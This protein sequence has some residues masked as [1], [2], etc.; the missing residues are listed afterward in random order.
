VLWVE[1]CDRD[2]AP[3]KGELDKWDDMVLIWQAQHNGEIKIVEEFW[4]VTTEPGKYYSFNPVNSN[5]AARIAFGQYKAWQRGLHGSGR[6]AHQGFRQE[7]PIRVFRDKN[8]DGSRAGDA[9]NNG[10]FYCNWH[11]TVDSPSDVGRW[12]AG[13]SVFRLMPE[14]KRFMAILEQDRRYQTN[15]AYTFIGAYCDGNELAKL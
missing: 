5:G 14:F 15:K 7:A 1:D 6:S 10:I 3:K 8:K 13:C 2:W 11:S 12:S 4:Q 9:V